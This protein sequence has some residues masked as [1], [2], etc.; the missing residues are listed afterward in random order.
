MKMDTGCCKYCGQIYT[1]ECDENTTTE[2]L[3]RRATLMCGCEEAQTAKM[4]DAKRGQAQDMI[5]KTMKNPRQGQLLIDS[6]QMLQ[7]HDID[8][9]SFSA[10]DTKVKLTWKEGDFNLEQTTTKKTKQTT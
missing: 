2:E 10:G 3:N 9:I 6:L 4:M 8:S 7:K 5:E 1:V